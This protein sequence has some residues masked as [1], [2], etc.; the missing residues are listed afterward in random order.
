MVKELSTRNTS[1]ANLMLLS[2]FQ[3]V[4]KRLKKAHFQSPGNTTTTIQMCLAT[5]KIWTSRKRQTT[6]RISIIALTLT[7]VM[8]IQKKWN[9]ET[10][11]NVNVSNHTDQQSLM[12]WVKLNSF[13]VSMYET[14]NPDLAIHK[15][16]VKLKTRKAYL[17][18]TGNGRTNRAT[19]PNI[20]ASM[21]F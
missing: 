11:R 14:A 17:R 12:I 16:A 21:C 9:K 6:V 4:S 3:M 13:S 1:P 7:C 15:V 2:E 20:W 8:K 5:T 18:N 19:P 10:K